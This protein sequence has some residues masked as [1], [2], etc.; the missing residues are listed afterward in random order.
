MN[1]DSVR[2]IYIEV[3]AVQGYIMGKC[4]IAFA[5]MMNFTS[6]HFFANAYLEDR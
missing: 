3:T 4:K 2:A 5:L 6:F 1:L